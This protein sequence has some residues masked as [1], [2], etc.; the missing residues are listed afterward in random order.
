MLRPFLEKLALKKYGF[1]ILE[2]TDKI[3]CKS[4]IRKDYSLNFSG[5][6]KTKKAPA[7]NAVSTKTTEKSRVSSSKTSGRNI[8]SIRKFDDFK[9]RVDYRLVNK[10]GKIEYDLNRIQTF[11]IKNYLNFLEYNQ[12]FHFLHLEKINII[13]TTPEVVISM[14]S[15]SNR[16]DSKTSQSLEFTHFNFIRSM[17]FC[18]KRHIS[19]Y[20]ASQQL[21]ELFV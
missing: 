17:Y 13:S 6:R 8:I 16:F 11:K 5:Y 1:N 3:P 2:S 4:F 20:A 14:G 18:K 12:Q 21:F 7:F 9:S 15:L 19:E 10:M